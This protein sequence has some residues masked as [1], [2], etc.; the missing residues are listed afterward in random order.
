MSRELIP[1]KEKFVESIENKIIKK[2]S[3]VLHIDAHLITIN[4]RSVA[5]MRLN[6]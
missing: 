2:S 3:G 6:R 5:V 1:L 4:T